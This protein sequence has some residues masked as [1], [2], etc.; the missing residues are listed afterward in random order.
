M[1]Y[2]KA[3]MWF[4]AQLLNWYKANKRNLP[5]R[6][7]KDPY[8]IW[9][10][11]II[12]QQTRVD[13]GLPYY[14]AFI[15]KFPD[16]ATLST[17]DER[18][19][20]KSWQGLGYYSRAR[21][22]HF[23][24]KTIMEQGG[25]FPE[26]YNEI[27]K[28]KGIGEYTAAAISS[29]CFNESNAV[30]DGNVYRVLARFYGLN[31][32]IDTG[33]GKKL[34]SSLANKVMDTSSPGDYNQAIMEFGALNCKPSNPD[35][36][37]CLLKPKC[38]A[39]KSDTV[40]SYPVKIKKLKKRDRYFNYI[41]IEGDNGNFYQKRVGKDIWQNMYEPLLI[42]SNKLLG[43][44]GILKSDEWLK[45]FGNKEDISLTQSGTMEHK[46]SHQTIKARFWKTQVTSSLMAA[47]SSL[48]EYGSDELKDIPI[49]RLIE[50]Y[51]E[52]KP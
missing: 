27:I 48:E 47:E 8:L 49:P 1:E 30:V 38:I 22:L 46:L 39:Y 32:A 18:D 41:V 19:V 34:F 44:N 31:E 6:E 33:R 40:E 17:A 50:K 37:S 7:T 10:S 15:K 9:I 51:F 42:E 5:W 20:L 23:A 4:S 28:L 52:S 25:E 16:V 12:L 26:S 3:N 2:Y 21:N 24:A 29:I 36:S 14:E 45:V 11:E 35:C 13:Q 43:K